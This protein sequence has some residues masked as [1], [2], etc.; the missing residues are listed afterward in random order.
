MN[1]GRLIAP[2]SYT[3]A[4]KL[5][6]AW[7]WRRRKWR[8]WRTRTGTYATI[9]ILS[10]CSQRSMA[11]NYFE[12]SSWG[13]CNCTWCTSWIKGG[14]HNGLTL[15]AGTGSCWTTSL[16]CLVAS[17]AGWSGDFHWSMIVGWLDVQSMP[18][19]C[20][21]N[22]CHAMHFWTCIGAF[23]FRTISTMTKSGATSSLTRSMSCPTQYNIDRSSAR[24][25]T[26]S[27]ANGKSVWQRVW[28]WP[29]SRAALPA[30]I[31]ARLNADRNQSW[32]GLAP[33]STWWPCRLSL[34]KDVS[35]MHVFGR[36]NDGNFGM[37][38]KN[39]ASIQKWINLMSL[40]LKDYKG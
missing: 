15:M 7:T 9:K 4:N 25:R 30:G 6:L 16:K 37:V 2:I 26:Q 5:C 39:C 12:V 8:G 10:G 27:I 20:W 35:C 32:S 28:Q 21:R 13:G 11:A 1:L 17:S 31:K 18:S 38:H 22:A 19:H 14:S 29:M 40:M 23:T 34:L 24:L 36:K 33:P 3:G